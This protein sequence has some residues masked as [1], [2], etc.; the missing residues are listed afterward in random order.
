M[1]SLVLFE[2]NEN[3]TQPIKSFVNAQL[4]KPNQ[5]DLDII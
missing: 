5:F 4:G 3:D 2:D 1:A